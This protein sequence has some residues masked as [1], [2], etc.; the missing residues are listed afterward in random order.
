MFDVSTANGTVIPTSEGNVWQ[1]QKGLYADQ[2]WHF[3]Q[4]QNPVFSAV[5]NNV[6]NNGLLV[7]SI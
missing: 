4:L 1:L 6:G 2:R 5:S 7:S 3:S